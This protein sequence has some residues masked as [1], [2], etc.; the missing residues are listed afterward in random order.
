MSAVGDAEG[1]LGITFPPRLRAVYAEGDGRFRADGQWWV[2]WP[3][4]RLI[5][6][7]EA[8]WRDRLLP[9]SF[10]AFGDDGTGNPWIW[11]LGPEVGA[12]MTRRA[13]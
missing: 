4:E 7:N 6:D 9:S 3:L 10:L 12:G 8:A 11:G 5:G 2:V 13:R 1:R